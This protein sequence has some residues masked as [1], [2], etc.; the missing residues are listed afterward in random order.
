MA[1]AKGIGWGKAILFGEHFV[2][3]GLPGI[4]TSIGLNTTCTFMENK[5]GIVSND[6]VTGETIRFGENKSKRLDEV[7]QIIFNETGTG[8]GNF[9]LALETDM[10]VRGGMGSSAAL[11]VSITKCLD[12]KFKLGFTNE[13]VNKIAYDVEKLF[14]SNPSGIDNTVSAYGGLI[15]FVRGKAENLIELIALKKPV[16]AVLIDTGIIRD[17]GE[18]VDFV[19]AQKRENE[20][21]SKKIFDQY[22]KLSLEAKEAIEKGEWKKVGELM[23]TNQQ[24]L[25]EMNVSSTEIEQIIKACLSS[26]AYGAKLTGAGLGGN[27]IALTPGIE[28]QQKV[29]KACEK[30]G[31]ATYSI[32]I[33]LHG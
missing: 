11:A 9:R 12:K 25:R 32:L 8:N 7:L 4:A 20:E 17:T 18:A 29:A 1:M 23:N 13:K 22:A 2:V 21:K 27:V 30:T 28:L 26:G 31:F 24:L 33:G 16:E 3:Y 6:L 5:S 19:A 15:W 14:H 10:S